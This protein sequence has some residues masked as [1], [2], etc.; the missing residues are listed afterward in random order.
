MKGD[1]GAT[2][3]EAGMPSAPA[4]NLMWVQNVDEIRHEWRVYKWTF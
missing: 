2:I 1:N 4:K 3:H